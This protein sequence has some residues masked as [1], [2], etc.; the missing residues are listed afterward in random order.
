MCTIKD[1]YDEYQLFLMEFSEKLITLKSQP[2][3]SK[4]ISM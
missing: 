3:T 4:D 2:A 1:V